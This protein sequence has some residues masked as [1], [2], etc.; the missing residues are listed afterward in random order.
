VA[1][2]EDVKLE[3]EKLKKDGVIMKLSEAVDWCSPL[4]ISHRKNG[5]I[6]LCIDYRRFNE[7]LRALVR[8]IPTMKEVL[9]QV[10]K[11]QYFSTLYMRNGYWH[12]EVHENDHALLAFG[13][14]FGTFTWRCLPFGLKSA[15]MVFQ[16]YV[17]TI[18]DGLEHVMIYMDDILLATETMEDHI[19]LLK[20]VLQ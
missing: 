19:Q 8:Q 10:G 2:W 15:P 6:R 4:V 13:T 18:L 14:P 1:Y 20:E 3:L 5:K 16:D 7:C 12:I 9:A 11:A 17:C